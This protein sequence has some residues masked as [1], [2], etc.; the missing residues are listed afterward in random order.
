MRSRTLLLTCLAVSLTAGCYTTWSTNGRSSQQRPSEVAKNEREVTGRIAS[1]T[2]APRGEMDG[3]VLDTG[4]RVH[5]PITAGS[6]LLPIVQ[7]GDVVTVTGNLTDRPEGKVIEAT[8]IAN[9]D[10]GKRID[11]ASITPPKPEE[12]QQQ[13]KKSEAVPPPGKT[14]GTTTLTGAELTSKEGR[15]QGYTTSPTGDMDGVLLDNGVRVHFAPAAGKALLPLVQQGKTIR[16]VGWEITGPEGAMIEATKI[17]ETPNGVSVDIAEVAPPPEPK[18]TPGAVAPPGAPPLGQ[19]K[20]EQQPK[21]K[22]QPK[23]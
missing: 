20:Q 22:H 16:V 4:N 10:K 6:T 13:A 8:T 23:R 15:V 14:K 11:V 17:S 21:T 5:F 7:K 1:Y 19:E 18:Q 9:R 3:F 2:T 12:E